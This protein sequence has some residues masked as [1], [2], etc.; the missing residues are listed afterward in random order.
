ML[1]FPTASTYTFSKGALLGVNKTLAMVSHFLKEWCWVGSS[2][3]PEALAH[4][5][6]ERQPLENG[7][8]VDLIANIQL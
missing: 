2:E 3:G 8:L 1:G 6:H 7:Q 4:L 5:G